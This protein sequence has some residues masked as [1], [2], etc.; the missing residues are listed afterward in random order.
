MKPATILITMPMKPDDPTQHTYNWATHAKEIA[1]DMGYDVKTIEKEN[2]TYTN[3]TD[4]IRKY[5]PALYC[6]WGHGC[7][8]SLQGQEE[9]VI[10]R[11]F[12]EN[13][14]I[15]MVNNPEKINVVKEMMNPMGDISC[16]GICKLPDDVCSPLCTNP[17]NVGE[18]RGTIVFATAC[19]SAAQLGLCAEKYGV[20]SYVGFKDLFMF[21]VDTQNSQ[22]IFGNVQLSFYKDLL[23]G[24]TVADA[25]QEMIKTEDSYIRKYKTVKYIALPLLWN[26]V[27]RKV[28][29]NKDAMIYQ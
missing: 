12:D 24:H 23:L 18:L 25:E 10:T 11:K 17:T 19:F 16:P 7:V 22:D 13:E 1:E 9:C 5:K 6:H 8:W 15:Q 20:R 3:V 29:G 14:L 26:R 27:H 21:P 4:A 2:T 28:I